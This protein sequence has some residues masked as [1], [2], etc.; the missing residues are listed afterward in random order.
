MES[1]RQLDWFAKP[2]RL[3]LSAF[4]S[5]VRHAGGWILARDLLR[6]T[7]LEDTEH[8]R[9]HLRALAAQSDAILSGQR[10]YCHLANA[11]PEDIHHAAAWLESQAREMMQRAIRLRRR[12]HAAIHTGEPETVQRHD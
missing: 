5:A 10:G 2:D 12:A 8:A 9:R 3:D 11:T 1:T 6:R 4:E 7:G